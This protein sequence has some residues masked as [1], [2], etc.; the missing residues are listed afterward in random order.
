MSTP[1][2]DR[3]HDPGSSATTRTPRRFALEP[4]QEVSRGILVAVPVLAVLLALTVSAVFLRLTGHDP[5]TVYR[6]MVRASFA[7]RFGIADTLVSAT[8]LILTGLAAVVSFRVKL[9]NI[10]AEG[11][12]YLGAV[13]AA[14]IA[15]LLG[16]RLAT[17][18]N[19]VLMLVAGALG[20]MAWI[21]IPALA[22]AWLRT[23]EI[24]TT[25]LLNSVALLF[26][27]W[28]IFGSRS[29]WRDPDSGQFPQG[30][31]IP[32]AAEF[33]RFGTT[34]VHLGLVVAVL[35][36]VLVWFVLTRTRFGFR[37]RVLGDSE[38]AAR[39]AGVPI[40][41]MVLA[42]LLLSGALAGIAGAAEVGGLS[43]RL[44]PSS[45]AIGLGYAGIIVAAL[46][47]LNPGG[48]VL[49]AVLLGGVRNAGTALQSLP[50][51]VPMEVAVML[52]GAIL[53]FA[54]GSEVLV[55]YRIRWPWS[56]TGDEPRDPAPTAAGATAHH[57]AGDPASD[58][59]GG[60]QEGPSA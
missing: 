36:A 19:V 28:L 21:A 27:N 48:V 50:D 22:R 12:L 52:E 58:L 1:T 34:R 44:D 11:Q 55:R 45:L 56:R 5:L 2:R 18:V 31:R 35:A 13:A 17:P 6:V 39:Y 43:R 51:R 53:L 4:R 10:G 26:I 54:L 14:G 24:I 57:P 20:G 25:L 40:R 29:I 46:A 7:S 3:L 23:N 15:L 49:V 42:V 47:R 33:P 16:D 37:M 9:W 32:Q 38:D 8:P 59:A 30:Q 41:G 60:A